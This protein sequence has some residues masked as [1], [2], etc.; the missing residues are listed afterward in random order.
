MIET[1]VAGVAALAVLAF[2]F[3]SFL[4]MLP[5]IIAS[6]SILTTFLLLLA[7]SYLT[8]VSF[9][10]QFLV[11]LVGLGVAIDY[12][13]LFVTRWREER[14]HG[15]S[16]EEALITTMATAGRAVSLSGLTVAIGLMSLIVLP[17][18][19]LRSTG[20]GGML[21]PLV[22]VAV[23]LTLLPAILA[24]VGPRWDWPRIRHEA[25][26]SRGWRAWATGVAKHP[27]LGLLAALLILGVAMSPALH[28]RIGQ[29]SAQAEAQSGSA[30]RVYQDL[31]SNGA[32]AGVITPMEVLVRDTR[33]TATARR[34]RG[35]AG[36]DTV[37]IVR[38]PAGTRDGYS[39]LIV[40][41][42]IE[43]VNSATL[44]PT[45]SVE[46]ALRTMPGVFGVTG[47]G[48]GQQA[49][50]SAVYGNVPLMLTV[51]AIL[52]FLL[53]ARAL[54]SLI[55]ATKAVILNLV[56]LAATFGALTWFWQNGH[57][58]LPIFR[59]TGDGRHHVLGAHHGVCVLVRALDG[60]RSLH[61]HPS[62]RRV[63]RRR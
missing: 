11:S 62:A 3:A 63:R 16:N 19:F 6:V 23:V 59:N 22:S 4:A 28:L 31:L 29:T 42:S 58:S 38:G 1:L 49:F 60:L 12:S 43:T 46:S 44:G 27:W 24:S 51:L 18:P 5:L 21:I 26:A 13:L 53:L 34:L 20:I 48:P 40:V 47:E 57:G 61:P 52:T 2:V 35:V 39:D 7:M 45:R 55:L 25:M 50:T 15:K 32:P 54:R 33:A 10:V 37:A 30:H 36:V 17:V 41:P 9:I 56:S 14:A 8:S